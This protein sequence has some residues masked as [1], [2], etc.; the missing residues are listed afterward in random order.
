MRFA[1]EMRTEFPLATAFLIAHIPAIMDWW[2]WR[3]RLAFRTTAEVSR[4]QLAKAVSPH[5]W[6]LF[7]AADLDLFGKSQEDFCAGRFPGTMSSAAE[8]KQV[9]DLSKHMLR[10]YEWSER[11]RADRN[12]RFFLQVTAWHEMVHWADQLDG[13]DNPEEMDHRFEGRA[14]GTNV[15]PSVDKWN[16]AVRLEH[17]VSLA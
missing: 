7:K 6:P 11:N 9:I 14:F 15:S 12:M 3:V 5:G 16:E 8:F 10:W 4:E 2:R 13:K 1:P 17:G